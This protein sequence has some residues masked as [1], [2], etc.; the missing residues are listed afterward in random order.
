MKTKT[1][2]HFHVLAKQV[3]APIPVPKSNSSFG[4]RYWNLFLVSD[5]QGYKHGWHLSLTLY[6]L[7]KFYQCPFWNSNTRWTYLS[8][9]F[10]I[11][12]SCWLIILI[13]RSLQK[14]D[15]TISGPAVHIFCACL[16][17][18]TTTNSIQVQKM[19]AKY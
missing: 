18:K 9:L 8:S 2:D 10:L 6:Q 13:D 16:I 11:N 1:C 15:V 5:C 19:S 14:Y 4:N 12:F 17:Q 7:T 3:S